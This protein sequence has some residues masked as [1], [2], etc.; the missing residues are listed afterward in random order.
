MSVEKLLKRHQSLTHSENLKVVSHVQRQDGDWVRH[1]VMIEDV[2]APFVFKRTKP[3]QSLQGA[4][5]NMTYYRT[6]ETVAGMEFE[7]MKVVRIKRA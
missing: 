1:T 5:V 4:R 6:V 2:D 3:Y 7:Q